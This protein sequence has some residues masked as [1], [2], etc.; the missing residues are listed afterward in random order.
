MAKKNKHTQSEWKNI[1]EPSSTG[2][3]SHTNI[4]ILRTHVFGSSTS[5]TIKPSVPLPSRTPSPSH[6][7]CL[8]RALCPLYKYIRR[9]RD[10]YL[11]LYVMW[12]C[13]WVCVCVCD[14]MR[15]A[16]SGHKAIIMVRDAKRPAKLLYTIRVLFFFSFLFI[17]RHHIPSAQHQNMLVHHVVTYNIYCY[18]C[19]A[20]NIRGARTGYRFFF[21]SHNAHEECELE[22]FW[23]MYV[24]ACVDVRLGVYDGIRDLVC[25]CLWW[26]LLWS[27]G[28]M[29]MKEANNTP[30]THTHTKQQS[31]MLSGAEPHDILVPFIVAVVVPLFA[32]GCLYVWMRTREL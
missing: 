20:C 29:C 14:G 17:C 27:I 1:P 21:S 16:R 6:P 12:I 19:E 4:Y 15:G 3:Q 13:V 8:F 5:Q 10:P 2:Q 23:V 25:I 7:V 18:I 11:E 31:Q 9:A 28:L 24:C 30:N 26:L 22:P 32:D